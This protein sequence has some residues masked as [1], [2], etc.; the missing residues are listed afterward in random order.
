MDSQL[1]HSVRKAREGLKSSSL[2]FLYEP[3][4]IR[5]RLGA[6]ATIGGQLSSPTTTTLSARARA[7]SPQPAMKKKKV[8]E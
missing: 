3:V 1:L 6:A 7:Q 5:M 4:R 8:E 2:D